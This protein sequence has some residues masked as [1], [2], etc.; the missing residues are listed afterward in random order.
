M[1][2]SVIFE[3]LCE[4]LVGGGEAVKHDTLTRNC[5]PASVNHTLVRYKKSRRHPHARIAF[6]LLQYVGDL[7]NPAVVLYSGLKSGNVCFLPI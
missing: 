4:C 6:A 5:W 3:L 2:I 7:L 1:H